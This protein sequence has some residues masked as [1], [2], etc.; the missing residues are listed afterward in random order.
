MLV[1]LGLITDCSYE[2]CCN[3]ITLQVELGPHWQKQGY[4]TLSEALHVLPA[5]E[6][7]GARSDSGD[8]YAGWFFDSGCEWYAYCHGSLRSWGVKNFFNKGSCCCCGCCC[9][10]CCCVLELWWWVWVWLA[11]LFGVVVVWLVFDELFVFS[12]CWQCIKLKNVSKT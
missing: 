11:L 4:S 7:L 9:G 5:V 1:N 8:L 2:D 6:Q 10:C 12:C 3:S